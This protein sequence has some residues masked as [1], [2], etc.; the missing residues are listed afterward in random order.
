MPQKSVD[1]EKL[2]N[3]IKQR[4]TQSVTEGRKPGRDVFLSNLMGSLNTGKPGPAVNKIKNVENDAILIENEKFNRKNKPIFRDTPV[5]SQSNYDMG[6]SG[7]S[8]EDQERDELLF[9][10]L[11]S[12]GKKRGLS[13]E[14]DGLLN[15]HQRPQQQN[16]GMIDEQSMSGTLKRVVESYLNENYGAVLEESVKNVMLE[17]YAQDTIRRVLIEDKELIKKVLIENKDIMRSLVIEVIRDI[18]NRKKA[19]EK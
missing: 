5:H 9:S 15:Q 6:S 13:E 12:V 2:K 14:F 4:K 3:E 11:Q 19:A 8:Q 7:S 18:Q 17:T 10:K 16:T 1:L